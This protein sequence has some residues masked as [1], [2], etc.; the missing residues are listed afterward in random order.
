M[1]YQTKE[2]RKHL[3]DTCNEWLAMGNAYTLQ[4]QLAMLQVIQQEILIEQNEL[5][6][7][8]LNEGKRN[9]L[10][11]SNT[12]SNMARSMAQDWADFLRD[13]RR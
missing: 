13:N 9:D 1:K 10:R 7:A 4:E 8:S 3:I 11:T 2:Q 5:I 6:L 12:V